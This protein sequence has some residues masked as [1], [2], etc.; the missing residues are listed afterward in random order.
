MYNE[1]VYGPGFKSGADLSNSELMATALL[2]LVNM[3]GNVT[4]LLDG[5]KKDSVFLSSIDLNEND[6][7]KIVDF[8]KKDSLTFVKTDKKYNEE[9]ILVISGLAAKL[10][11]NEEKLY[12]QFVGLGI[13]L[14]DMWL[15]SDAFVEY[16][17][18]EDCINLMYKYFSR[19]NIRTRAYDG[20]VSS[21]ERISNALKSLMDLSELKNA[22]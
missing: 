20:S 21:L 5:Y 1:F 3:S 4:S 2:E 11:I 19:N 12:N 13:N 15:L 8:Y 14:A 9:G 22:A 7:A 18:E 17:K 6:M 16:S 10:N